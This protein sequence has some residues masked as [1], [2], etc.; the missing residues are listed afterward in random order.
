[1][2][3]WLYHFRWWLAGKI[4]GLDIVAEI[5]AAYDAGVKYGR[6]PLGFRGTYDVQQ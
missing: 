1:M 6:S 5:D 4:I 3:D 2:S